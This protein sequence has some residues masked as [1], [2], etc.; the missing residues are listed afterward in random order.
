LRFKEQVSCIG[1]PFKL[2]ALTLVTLGLSK[3]KA[4][5]VLLKAR[6]KE[7]GDDEAQGVDDD[8]FIDVYVIIIILILVFE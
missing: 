8:T 4:G 5:W 6:Q 1:F 7:R 2:S 3:Y